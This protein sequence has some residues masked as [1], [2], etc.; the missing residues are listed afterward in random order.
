MPS[1]LISILYNSTHLIFIKLYD[2][3]IIHIL[4]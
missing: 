1:I 2:E 4:E 3:D